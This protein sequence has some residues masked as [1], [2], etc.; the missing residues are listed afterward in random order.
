MKGFLLDTNV[1]SEFNRRR[2]PDP[3]VKRWLETTPNESLYASVLTLGEIRM[4]I[5][6]LP[7]SKKRTGL[8]KWFQNDLQD[9]F[10]GRILPIDEGVANRWGVLS[11]QAQSK[12]R[13]LPTIDSLLAATAL[14]HSLTVVSRNV[15]DFLV[16]G[17]EVINPWES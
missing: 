2:D 9:W 8:E 15:N 11:A 17:L 6:L 13:P 3:R 4:G 7:P 16:A 5:E 1:L 10:E 12:G 14:Q